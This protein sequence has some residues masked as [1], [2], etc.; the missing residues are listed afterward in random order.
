MKY[1]NISEESK[2]QIILFKDHPLTQIIIRHVH[3]SKHHIGREYTFGIS[4]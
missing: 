2:H 3:G 4:R 1:A